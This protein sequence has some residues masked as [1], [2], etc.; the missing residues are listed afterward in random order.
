MSVHKPISVL[1]DEGVKVA[2][3]VPAKAVPQRAERAWELPPALH[4]AFAGSFGVYLLIMGSAAADPKLMVPFAVFFVTIGMFF[5]VPAV[6]GRT[7]PRQEGRFQ[8]WAQ[9]KR[10]KLATY[11]GDLSGKAVIV[12]MMTL[13]VVI[14]GWALFIKCYWAFLGQ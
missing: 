13:P 3:A 5:A 10:E 1:A 11:S 14:L 2:R 12:Q 4:W 7:M 6:I 8:S 9:F